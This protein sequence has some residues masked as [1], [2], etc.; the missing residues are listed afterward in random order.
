MPEL[1]LIASLV[2]GL[3]VLGIAGDLLV[4]GA[5][6]LGSRLGLSPLVAGIFIVGFGTSAPEMIVA[7]DAAQSGYPNLALGNIVGSN[8]ANV[9]LVLALPAII[10]PISTGNWGQGTAWT[11]MA[12]ATAAW[13]AFLSTMGLNAS[14]AGLF[15]IALVG[16]A[17]FTFVAAKAATDAGIDTGVEASGPAPSGLARAVGFTLIGI[18]GL[19]LGAQ[20]IVEGGVEIAQFYGVPQELI[21]LTLLAVGTSLPEIGAGVA[22][23]LRAKTDVLVGN[24]L[25]SNIF[26]ILGAGGLISFVGVS[27]LAPSF[28]NYDHWAMAA[29]AALLGILILFRLRIGRLSGVIMLLLYATYIYGLVNGWNIREMVGV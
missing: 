1:S 3:L 27:E 26:N 2:G 5:V 19:P 22:S 24:V 11:A 4:N 18:V 14:V 21:G 13:I 10:A 7:L 9:L 6:S 29:A 12:L 17:I 25:G 15:L 8:I 23:A 28:E 20:L 16:Y